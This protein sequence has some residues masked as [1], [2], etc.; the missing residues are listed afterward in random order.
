MLLEQGWR[1]RVQPADLCRDAVPIE[2]PRKDCASAAISSPYENAKSVLD[3]AGSFSPGTAYILSTGYRLQPGVSSPHRVFTLHPMKICWPIGALLASIFLLTAVLSGCDMLR[4]D[5]EAVRTQLRFGTVLSATGKIPRGTAGTESRD[6]AATSNQT[7][8]LVTFT[9]VKLLVKSVQIHTE[10]GGET[11]F[12]SES[13]AVT[14]Q[15]G[16]T[17]S[18]VVVGAVP[19]GVYDQVTFAI[20]KPESDEPLPDPEF[21]GGEGG[22]ERYSTIIR[23]TPV[24]EPFVVKIN[25]GFQQR[26]RLNPPLV[27]AEGDQAVDITLLADL[28]AWFT[29]GDGVLLNPNSLDDLDA[30]TRAME[31]SFRGLSSKKDWGGD[32]TYFDDKVRGANNDRDDD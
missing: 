13:F 29:G 25:K 1:R 17:A 3:P 11:R 30:I 31:D 9:E 28:T 24:G 14:L 5:S 15:P 27:V 19:P 10:G 2:Q 8:D 26:V 7:A 18:T 21:L 20:H 22:N 12:K 4:Q 16:S 32:D 6:T 23:G